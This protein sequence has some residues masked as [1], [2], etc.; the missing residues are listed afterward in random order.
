MAVQTKATVEAAITLILVQLN[1]I[2][3]DASEAGIA[4]ENKDPR[5]PLRQLDK[6]F[7]MDDD[8]VFIANTQYIDAI[9]NAD[10]DEV[11]NTPSVEAG[12]YTRKI[13]A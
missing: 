7:N 11:I 2:V 1:V 6:L 5:A 4:P 10:G 12:S 3:K 13:I 9:Y 8:G